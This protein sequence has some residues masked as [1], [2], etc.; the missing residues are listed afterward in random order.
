MLFS[1]LMTDFETFTQKLSRSFKNMGFLLPFR[2]CERPHPHSIWND[3]FHPCA[4]SHHYYEKGP[5]NLGPVNCVISPDRINMIDMIIYL[6]LT[7]AP[8]NFAQRKI[9]MTMR[10]A[11]F[12][13]KLAR[14]RLLNSGMEGQQIELSHPLK[15]CCPHR[16]LRFR[17]GPTDQMIGRQPNSI[18]VLL[19]HYEVQYYLYP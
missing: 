11:F 3:H 1:P 19:L 7:K 14:Q 18:C 8:T 12:P 5:L 13:E 16:S 2:S 17:I 9:L 4:T 6:L 15:T 10:R